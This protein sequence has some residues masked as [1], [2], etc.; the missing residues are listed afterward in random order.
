MNLLIGAGLGLAVGAL[1]ALVG[2]DRGRSYYAVILIVIAT[3]YGLFAVMA[4]APGALV[5]EALVLGGFL[6]AAAIGFRANLWLVVVGLLAHGGMDLV[7]GR[8]I[9]NPGVPVWWPGFCMACDVAL[10]ACLPRVFRDQGLTQL[11]VPLGSLLGMLA[12]AVLVGVVAAV[13]PAVRAA[14]LPVLDA[15]TQ[16]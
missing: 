3:Y 15:I 10:A 4:G 7:H 13:W 2:F 14:R 16:E 6:L 5:P 9:D 1:G 8:V 12:L 11:A